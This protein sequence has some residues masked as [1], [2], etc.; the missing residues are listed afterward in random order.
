MIK[1]LV[2]VIGLYG[3]F[4]SLIMKVAHYYNWHYAPPLYPEGDTQ[5]WCRW[6][7]FQ[8]TIKKAERLESIG[9]GS[10]IPQQPKLKQ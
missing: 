5:L 8:A 7:G 6:C 9:S 4:Y 1:K 10:H 2:I 3:Y